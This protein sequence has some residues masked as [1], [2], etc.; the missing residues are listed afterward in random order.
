MFQKFLIIYFFS[1]LTSCSTPNWY[2]PMGYMIFSHMPKEGSPG[3][4]LGWIHGCQ[5]GLGSQFA[6][7]FYMDFY[8][9]SR[10][11]DITS[12]SP[13]VAKIRE[14]YKKE[15][16]DVNWNNPSDVNKNF[17][18][19][20]TIFWGAHSFCRH[21]I[22][23]TQQSAGMAPALPGQERWDPM[24]HNVGSIW[25]MNGRGD[26]RIGSAGLW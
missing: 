7:A 14:R 11:P 13:D 12:G 23:S 6:N 22:L 8:T 9:W 15:L 19:Y 4:H 17:S 2:K 24:K 25:K 26:V 5:S 18:D 21:S 20:N 1:F 10:D 3:F 16:K